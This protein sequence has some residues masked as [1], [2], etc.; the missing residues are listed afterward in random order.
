MMSPL[1]KNLE[2]AHPS[3]FGKFSHMRVEHIHAGMFVTEFK[4]AALLPV[5]E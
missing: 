4:D 5:L 1:R 2:H 3:E